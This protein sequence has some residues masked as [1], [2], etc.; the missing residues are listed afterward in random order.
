MTVD[1]SPED[2]KFK[3]ER[4][5]KKRQN[6]R[7]KIYSFHLTVVNH[8]HVNDFTLAFSCLIVDICTIQERNNFQY[9]R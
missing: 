2:L 9:K 1:F 7:M 5:I 3:L 8:S 4:Q 6:E